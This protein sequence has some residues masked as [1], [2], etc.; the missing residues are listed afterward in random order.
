MNPT[1]FFLLTLLLVL[2]TEA[3]ARRPRGEWQVCF[4][5]KIFLKSS[6]RGPLAF[7][8]MLCSPGFYPWW[9][10][11]LVPTT[12]F[13]FSHTFYVTIS[14][15]TIKASVIEGCRGMC[16]P[17]C[18]LWGDLTSRPFQLLTRLKGQWLYRQQNSNKVDLNTGPS[19]ELKHGLSTVSRCTT[20]PEYTER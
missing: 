10:L 19:P 18:Q 12:F 3:S 2:V 20:N 9:K 5:G 15:M 1:S 6:H 17:H 4:M 11:S 8:R 13:S 14:V 16:D 7:C